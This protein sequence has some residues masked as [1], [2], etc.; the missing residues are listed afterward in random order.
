[1]TFVHT[2]IFFCFVL[3]RHR[4]VSNDMAATNHLCSVVLSGPADGPSSGYG[5]DV[6]PM[7]LSGGAHS[8]LFL[9]GPLG[10]WG[11]RGAPVSAEGAGA[12]LRSRWP[13]LDS[14]M[15][16]VIRPIDRRARLLFVSVGC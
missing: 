5:G 13:S 15:W 1:M 9:L 10:P 6:L 11:V 3:L 4:L 7:T 14:S 8:C 2:D 16:K 12:R